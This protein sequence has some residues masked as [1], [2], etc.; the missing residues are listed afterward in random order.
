M[1]DRRL[2]A[3]VLRIKSDLER[4]SRGEVSLPLGVQILDGE[5]TLVEGFETAF[6]A[7]GERHD[8]QVEFRIVLDQPRIYEAAR[9]LFTELLADRVY[10]SYEEFSNDAFRDVDTWMSE[11]PVSKERFLQA[12]ESY[13][14]FFCEDGRSGLGAVCHE[15]LIEVFV[16]EHG[17]ISIICDLEL[18]PRVE[19]VVESL[20]VPENTSLPCVEDW[21]HQHR[22]ILEV[23]EDELLMDDLDIKFSV[24]ESL[25]M[26]PTNRDEGD[27]P[28]LPA[29]Y[30]IELE[31]DLGFVTD[32]KARVALANFGVAAESWEEALATAET[33]LLRDMPG[34]LVARVLHVYR[35]L[36]EDVGPEIRPENPLQLKKKGIWYRGPVQNWF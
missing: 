31:L 3:P 19:S 11:E 6:V 33:D 25:G 28:D 2:T 24:I 10:P 29:L 1:S 34:V 13:G 30:W 15:P 21:E 27:A 8:D 16:E 32:A 20:G 23:S 4:E 26:Q 7:G 5:A 22:D 9:K 35:I 14:E 12:W 36:E 17:S 18:R